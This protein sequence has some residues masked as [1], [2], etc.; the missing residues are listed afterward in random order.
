[1]VINNH[2]GNHPTAASASEITQVK[3]EEKSNDDRSESMIT[4]IRASIN[5][6]TQSINNSILQNSSCTERSPGVY[7]ILTDP[8]HAKSKSTCEDSSQLTH[9]PKSTPIVK[10]QRV[11]H[12][13]T[14]SRRRGLKGLLA[15]SSDSSDV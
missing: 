8:K 4:P 1:M 5:S 3:K 12:H 11:M 14:P 2:H 13:P 15:E 9:K 10:A 7:F 6:N